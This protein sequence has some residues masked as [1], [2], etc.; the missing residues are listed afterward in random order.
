M[1]AARF[2]QA[3]GAC[4]GIVIARAVCPDLFTA[5]EAARAFAMLTRVMGA[6]PI[7]AP[8]VGA[9]LLIWLRLA[10]QRSFGCWC[11]SALSA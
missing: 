6:A 5:Q 11:C 3:I 2:L 9:Y 7:I 10:A 8:S 4:A 1:A